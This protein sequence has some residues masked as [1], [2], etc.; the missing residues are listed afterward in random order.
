MSTVAKAGKA[1]SRE[2]NKSN[3]G[4]KMNNFE[5]NIALMLLIKKLSKR[6]KK[7]Y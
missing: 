1:V 5:K 4:K 7:Y 2:V 3:K 6:K